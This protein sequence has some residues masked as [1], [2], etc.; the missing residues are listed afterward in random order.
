MVTIGDEG[1]QNVK[2]EAERGVTVHPKRTKI[3]DTLDDSD[4]L[5]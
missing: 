4:V 3:I 5:R 2:G 1:K